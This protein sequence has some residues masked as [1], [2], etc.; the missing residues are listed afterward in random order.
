M[1]KLTLDTPMNKLDAF[2]SVNFDWTRQLKSI[3]RDPSYHVPS[4]HQ[5][6]LNELVDYFVI[7]TRD[8]DPV[9]EPLGRV[10][11]GPAGYG[12]THLIGEL[13][14]RVWEMEGC[15]VLLDLVG[16]KDFWFSVALGFLNSL[17]VRLSEH[18]TQYDRL[19]LKLASLLNVDQ[20]MMT[21]ANQLRGR[22][23]E[24]ISALVKL[25]LQ[26]LSRLHF[27][28]TSDHR[29]TITALVLLISEDL[30]CHSIAHAWLQGMNL[31]PE[32]VRPLGFVGQNDPIKVVQG[33]SWIMSLV[34][35]TLIA[36]DQ[37]DAIVSASN[38][39]IRSKN[40]GSKDE[41][42]E[43]QLIVDALAQGLMDL[44][45]KKLRAVTVISCLEA[46]WKILEDKASVAVT[47]RYQAPAILRSLPNPELARG[48]VSARLQEA[49]G[50]NGFKPPYHTWPFAESA[51][52]TAIGFSPRQL[53]KACETHRQQCIA[54]GK[55]TD[56]VT[57]A[58]SEPPPK[59]SG[60]E[61]DAFDQM[62]T[63]ELKSASVPS[64]IGTEGE[65]WLRELLDETLRLFE[66]HLDLPDDIDSEVQQ[67]PDQKRPSL[68]GRLS[69]TFHD[70]GDRERHYCFRILDHTNAIA[71]Q[72]RLKAA[73][74]A[75]GIDTAL[76]FRHLFILRAGEP[77]RGPK[78]RALTDQF[79]GA[80][81][82]FIL[83]TEDDLRR[84]VALRA[85]TLRDLTDFDSWLRARKPLFETSL[86]KEAGLAP[87]PFLSTHPP[88]RSDRTSDPS[89][90]VSD[91]PAGGDAGQRT[92]T[93]SDRS[94]GPDD[95]P[96]RSRVIPIGRR[97]ERG[98]L[99][100]NVVL[101][102]DLL[103]RHLAILAGSGSG[104][105]VL[106]RRIVEEAALL[107][108]PSIVLDINNDLSRLGC[109][110]PNRPEGFSNEDQAKAAA[111]HA[112]A[113]VIVWTPGVSS[114]NPLSLKLL[115]DFAAIGDGQ[116]AQ[117]EDER[118]QAIEMA[119]ETL[120]PFL[121][122]SGQRAALKQGV[123]ADALRAFAKGGGPLDDLIRLLSKLPDNVSRIGNAQ[124]LAG[125]IANQLLA[126]VA[127]NPL[128]KTVGASVDPGLLF[129]G[130]DG[131]TRVSVVNLAG[132]ASNE[133]R[134]S[135]VNQLQMTLFTW[136]K[137]NPSPTARLYVLDEAQNF[138]P[139]QIKTA[140]KAS[141]LSLVAQARKY[142]LGM[143]FATQLPKGIDNAI[144]SNCT[145][146]IYGRMSSPATIQATQELMAA[147]GG[148]AEDIARLSRGEFYFSTDGYIRP[149]KVHT[150][151]CLSWHPP[152]P[153]TAQEVIEKARKI[154]H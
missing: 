7:R 26:S 117:T 108:I 18:Q 99:C 81:G 92:T 27:H 22:P 19:I 80:G 73:M 106:L 44:H 75:S 115:P 128:L 76:K 137:Q 86:F 89:V 119:R 101:K 63:N 4:L 11:I 85:M 107:G 53:L 28:E 54:E 50:K 30:D 111:Y 79:L 144:I 139:S 125:E 154:T 67:D 57:F 104:K 116:D 121:G 152:N 126:A 95:A 40:N 43:A 110:W 36:V 70:E 69:F 10:I 38:A 82:K 72:S 147:K 150:P 131:K 20:E 8:P 13:R 59:P 84:F 66:R 71:F 34:G 77:P 114:G 118:T 46:T 149:V 83:P 61:T 35:P 148:A 48:L 42:E 52:K 151:M 91:K 105:T 127:T 129:N 39:Q 87:P 14:H 47:D 5:D 45:E 94:T 2:R 112:R 122:G 12:K 32:Q 143:M 37:I 62:Y 135:F 17:Q 68:H 123:L 21:I 88:T 153:P 98:A 120:T 130:P 15:F 6:L 109:P 16:V 136:I 31:D 134:Q 58:L 100:D 141:A 64:L 96:G 1:N 97:L 9:D 113:D 138:A 146:H 29:D 132:L 55:V 74:T 124:K 103:P 142:G 23:R 41:L 65:A 25:F 78:T 133:A 60:A 93:E 49:Y 51:F 145:T 90:T 33:L 140:C 102:A 24:L 3:W 56:C